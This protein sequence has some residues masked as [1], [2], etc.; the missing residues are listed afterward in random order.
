MPSSFLLTLLCIDP[1]TQTEAGR[2]FGTISQV[3]PTTNA[4][5]EYC[6]KNVH[7]CKSWR[8]GHGRRCLPRSS[9]FRRMF[10][11]SFFCACDARKRNKKKKI[12]I[13]NTFCIIEPLSKTT[14]WIALFFVVNE[15][16]S[17]SFIGESEQT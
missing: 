2:S 10:H 3:S 1:A 9:V 12:L 11:F 7:P 8:L 4:N 15:I 17:K 6:G 16:Y 14:L 5:R 13:G